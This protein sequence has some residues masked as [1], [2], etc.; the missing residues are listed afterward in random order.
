MERI[1]LIIYVLTF[2][3][4]ISTGQVVINDSLLYLNQEPP[5]LSPK[6]F[7]PEIISTNTGYEFGIAVSENADEIYY[8][9]RLDEEWNAEIR[10]AELKDG[11]RTK[12]AKLFPNDTFSCN[13]P[14]LSADEDKLYFMSDKAKNVK[15]DIKDSDLWYIKKKDKGW[16]E[17]INVG[18]PINSAK[19]EFYISFSNKGTI[20]FASNIHTSDSNKWDYDIYYAEPENEK[21][22]TPVRLNDSINTKYFEVDAFVSSDESYMI[23]CSTRPGGLGKGDLYISFK[24]VDNIWSKAIN[25]GEIIN[26]EH[27]EF[28]PFVTKDGK[29]LFYTSKGDIYWVDSQIIDNIREKSNK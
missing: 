21:F 13:D 15:D 7:A 2:F 14:F 22:K 3:I 4:K 5:G 25:M 1:F 12:P 27:H 20:Y 28:C 18:E 10:F 24:N 8:A 23:F 6:V 29:Y 9:V 16:S 17:P 11:I 26:T 19:N